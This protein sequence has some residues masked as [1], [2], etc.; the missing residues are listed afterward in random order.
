MAGLAEIP[1]ASLTPSA[2]LG[3]CVLMLFLGKIVPRSTLVDAQEDAR[4][5]RDAYEHERAAHA[6][7]SAQLGA[8]LEQGRLTNAILDSAA[9]NR[10]PSGG[11]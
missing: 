1:F 7:T 6:E 4:S 9:A 10:L 3:I 5:W 8:S 11:P 2:L